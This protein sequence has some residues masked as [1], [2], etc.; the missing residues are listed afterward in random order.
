MSGQ[1][2]IGGLL[3]LQ[4][5]RQPF[6]LQADVKVGATHARV[7][8]TL[9][10]PRNLGAL[11]LRLQ[12]SGRSL[13]ELYPLTGVTLPETPAYATDGRL[14]ARLREAGGAQFR[15]QG[16]NG[17]I[18]ASDIHGELTFVD[19]APRPKLSG[20][21]TSNQLLFDDLAPLIGADSNA[22]KKARGA[23]GVQPADKALPVEAFRT[24]RWRAMDADVSFTGKHI[25]HGDRL[26]FDDLFTHI[27]LNDGLLSLEPLRFSIAGGRLDANIRL[28]GGVTPLQGRAQLK[29]RDFKLKQL[30]P[31]FAPL[32]TSL[33]E[34][35]GDAALAG[36]GNSVA[37]LLGSANGDLRLLVN[38][39]AV[40]RDLME[41]AGLNVGNYL[42]G[43]LFGDKPVKINCAVADAGIKDGLLGTRQVVFDTENAI[44]QVEGTANFRN[45][46]LDLDIN[47]DSKGLRII[48]LR[49][50]LYVGGTF[51]SPDAGVKAGPLLARGAGLLALGAVV[52]PAAG[53]LALI[54]PGESAPSQC[55]ALLK[56][57]QQKP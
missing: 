1:G 57:L 28:N 44:V 9:S 3:A 6:P 54:A 24:E 37:A 2:K 17:S 33:G 40:S 43:K 14:I 55:E 23:T 11:D 48:S 18:G 12:L 34:L 32:Q 27:M 7:A 41:I 45:E 56:K 30:F 4:D 53:V 35:N 25:V 50:P 15:Y 16:F 31:T 36:T 47:P 5:A 10:G 21:L 49:S 19:R 26:P 51:K 39:G 20:T 29:A 13:A 46:R 42:I 22:E 38:D 8:G 52:A